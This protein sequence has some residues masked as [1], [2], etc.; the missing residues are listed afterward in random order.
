MTIPVILDR[1]KTMLNVLPIQADHR[2]TLLQ[3]FTNKG[4]G[5]LQIALKAFLSKTS[6]WSQKPV[7]AYLLN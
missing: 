2:S 6:L 7:H 4:R 1:G 3:N 5:R